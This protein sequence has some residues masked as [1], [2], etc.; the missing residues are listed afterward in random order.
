[1]VTEAYL[2]DPCGASSLPFWKTNIVRVPEDILIL[3]EDDPRFKNLRGNIDEPYF[4]LIHR[5]DWVESPSLP[6]GFRFFFPDAA[7]LSDHIALCYERERISV[8]ELMMYRRHPTFSPDLWLAIDDERTGEIVA[9]GIA[10]LDAS[11]RE[12][13]L[14]W[15]QVSPTHRKKGWGRAVVC[16]LLR[17]MEGRADFVTVSGREKDPCCPQALYESC[18]FGGCVLWHVLRRV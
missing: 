6:E 7:T 14:E 16:E 18:G 8:E 15:I 10:E 3:R 17:R 11:I 2:H 4:K 9:S 5:M 12:G 1:M 13:V